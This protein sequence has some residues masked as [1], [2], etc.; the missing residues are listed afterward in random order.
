MPKVIKPRNVKSLNSV[1]MLHLK[2]VCKRGCGPA[3]ITLHIFIPTV[4]ILQQSSFGFFL[5]KS[6][7]C[8]I[9]SPLG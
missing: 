1:Y 6:E 8:K 4:H 9:N 5:L 3:N 2:C 7:T